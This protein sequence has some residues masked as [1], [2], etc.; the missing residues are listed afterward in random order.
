VAGVVAEADPAARVITYGH[1]ADGNVHVN[2][3]PAADADGRHEQAVF[4]FVASLGGSISAEHGIGALKARW[5]RLARTDA[6]RA[7]FARIRSALDPA[8]T[9]NPHVLPRLAL[10]PR[11][12]SRRYQ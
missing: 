5:L 8:G 3:V 4:S 1:V 10:L 7:L 11:L 12:P 9:L 6:E 2:I